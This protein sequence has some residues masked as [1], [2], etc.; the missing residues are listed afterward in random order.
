MAHG[1]QLMGAFGGHHAR[2][3]RRGEHI[4]LLE[5]AGQDERQRLAAHTNAAAG[6]GD[7]RRVRLLRYVD[8]ASAAPIIEMAEEFGHSKSPT[9][10]QS[11]QRSSLAAPQARG[12]RRRRDRAGEFVLAYSYVLLSSCRLNAGSSR[13]P[14]STATAART[15]SA[16]WLIRFFSASLSSAMVQPRSGTSKTGS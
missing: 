8:H 13:R 5:A 7:A 4:A 10:M 3:L 16:R 15:A 1:D 6:D 2:D 14:A 9:V 11:L 12:A